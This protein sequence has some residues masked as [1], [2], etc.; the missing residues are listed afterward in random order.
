LAGVTT[1][2]VL[3]YDGARWVNIDSDGCGPRSTS[4]EDITFDSSWKN[5]KVCIVY[6][7]TCKCV[8]RASTMLQGECD[9][10]MRLY[11]TEKERNYI[12]H[13]GAQ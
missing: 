8:M 10:P 1:M 13:L 4:N 6:V 5:T 3:S 12:F 9:L 11:Y 2:E 7:F